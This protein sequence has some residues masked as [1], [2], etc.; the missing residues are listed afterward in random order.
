MFLRPKN[1]ILVP[2]DYEGPDSFFDFEDQI[3]AIEKHYHFCK[4][5]DLLVSKKGGKAFLVFENPRKGVILKG[6]PALLSREAPFTIF[7]DPDYVGLNR[8]PLNEELKAYQQAYPDKW[9]P[10]EQLKWFDRA[11]QN[12]SEVDDFLKRCRLELGPLPIDQ[13][14]PLSFFSTWGK[15]VEWPPEL[16]EFGFS[17]RHTLS[18]ESLQKKLQFFDWQLKVRPKVARLV[19]DQIL[20]QELEVLEKAG[21]RVLVGHQKGEIT[22]ESSLWDVPVWSLV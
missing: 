2:F 9:T 15:L 8:L 6:I 3:S 14:D 20:P 21:I 12:P 4:L 1:S 22:K 17:I 5:S 10:S 7:V 19:K 16:V 11:I 13:L 18:P